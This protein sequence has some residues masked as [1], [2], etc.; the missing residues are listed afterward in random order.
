MKSIEISIGDNIRDILTSGCVD[1]YVEWQIK[2]FVKEEARSLKILPSC[3]DRQTK[4][5]PSLLL[6][7][8]HHYDREV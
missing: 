5:C 1:K 6:L 3:M 7:M 4:Y 8:A 2:N